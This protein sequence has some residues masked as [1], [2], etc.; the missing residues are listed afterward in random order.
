MGPTERLRRASPVPP[1]RCP[2]A[3]PQ[4]VG[5]VA[6]SVRSARGRHRDSRSGPPIRRPAG[7][8]Q[9]GPE[10]GGGRDLRVPRSQRGRQDHHGA[11]ARD[12]AA[13]QRRLGERGRPRRGLRGGACAPSDRR[14]A[15]G[16]RARPAHDGARADAA[17]GHAARAA[18]GRGRAQGRR[19]A[20]ARGPHTRSRTPGGHLLG[21][22]APPAGPRHGARPR[23]ARA[24]PRRAHDGPRPLVAH[25][26]LERGPGAQQRGHD[27]VPHHAVPRGGRPA[28]GPGGH[29][30]RG[31]HGGRGHARLAQGRGGKRSS[32]SGGVEQRQRQRA[33]G[34]RAAS[35]RCCRTATAR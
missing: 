14:R 23:A 8:G 13:T 25:R 11:H 19:P 18:Q 35:A 26:D 34:A 33:R 31:A 20:R 28:G 22:H 9:G 6:R 10:R 16:G 15:A 7:R 30:R 5:A 32:R 4:P 27:G 3:S 29:H 1:Y 21:R 12:A 17:P 24:L 2:D